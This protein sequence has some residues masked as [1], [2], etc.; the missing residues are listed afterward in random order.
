[1]KNMFLNSWAAENS[2]WYNEERDKFNENNGIQSQN[3]HLEF[4]SINEF[5]NYI[6]RSREISFGGT[7]SDTEYTAWFKFNLVFIAGIIF[8]VKQKI[9]PVYEVL[10]VTSSDWGLTVMFSWEQTSYNRNTSGD[11]TT[12]NIYGKMKYNVFIDGIG[13]VYTELKQFQVV[14]NNKTGKE[15]SGKMIK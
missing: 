3:N 1:M 12:I 9:T 8:Y 10:E 15:V 5:K 14:V 11:F 6:S 2:I 4:N 13:T 7:K